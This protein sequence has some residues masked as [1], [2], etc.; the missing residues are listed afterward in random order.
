MPYINSLRILIVDDEP[1]IRSSLQEALRIDGYDV[2]SASCADEALA[3]I[4]QNSIDIVITDLKMPGLSG[5]QLLKVVKDKYPQIAVVL[6]TGHGNIETAVEAMKSGAFDYITKPLVDSEI[7][8][9]I[10]KIA[11][12]KKLIQENAFLKEKLAQ[13]TR[14]NFCDMFGASNAMQK[15]YRMIETIANTKATI[16]ITGESGTGKRLVAMAIHKNDSLRNN[17]PFIEVSCGAL[18][19]NLLESELFGHV[20]GAF[21]GAIR[22]RK[23]RFELADKGTIFLDEIDTFSPSLQVKLLRVLQEG[24]F[25]HVGSTKTIRTDTRIIAATNQNLEKLINDGKFREDLFYRLNVISISIPPLRERKED[26]PILTEHFVKKYNKKNNTEVK[27]SAEII[28]IFSD[29]DWPGNVRELENAVEHA[30][31]VAKHGQI[32]QPAL[33]QHILRNKKKAIEQAQNKNLKNVL[34]EPER[35]IILN[36]LNANRWNRKKT[37]QSLGINRCTLY[38]KMKRLNI[39]IPNKPSS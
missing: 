32:T 8:V 36:S 13:A 14:E 9:I 21:T 37:A 1:L 11:E 18:P 38:N 20:K 33:P 27:I 39:I 3:N 5:M 6:I 16:L 19:E 31:V 15:I 2:K 30:V 22:D 10:Q 7:K 34:S 25:E 23:G 35:E 4:S 28:K 17:M 26:I 24:D 12:Q 29:Y